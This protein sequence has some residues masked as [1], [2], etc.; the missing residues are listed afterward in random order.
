MNYS[1]QIRSCAKDFESLLRIEN[2]LYTL[3]MD[4]KQGAGFFPNN[5]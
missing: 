2:P 1:E 4:E 5:E 3:Y